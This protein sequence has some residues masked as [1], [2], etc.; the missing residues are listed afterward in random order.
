[1]KASKEGRN[2]VKRKQ[3]L[4]LLLAALVLWRVGASRSA[5]VPADASVELPAEEPKYVALTFDDGPR[6]STTGQLLDGLLERG[7]S[8]TFF[9]VG[10]QIAGNEDLVL[11]M[12]DEEHQVGNH[13]WSHEQLQGKSAAT[14][15]SE[16]QKTDEALRGILG[17]GS[18]WVRPPYG[19]LNEGQK[20]LFTV[21]LVHWSVDP[22]DW[23]LR[24]TAKD[25]DAVLDQVFPGAI[26][27]MHDSVTQSVDAALQIVDELQ[28]QGYTFVTVEELLR[29]NGVT[30]EPGVFYL[31]AHEWN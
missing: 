18:Y 24:D 5:V 31:S 14:V 25:V 9:L 27:L 17:D 6:S 1:M 20:K 7:A 16:I 30:P 15:L 28:S 8:A 29:L 3:G 2:A 4:F 23:K 10:Q 21:P 11:R 22:E 19:L 26:I 13:S 12:R